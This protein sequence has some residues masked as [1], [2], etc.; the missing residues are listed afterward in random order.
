MAVE[1]KKKAPAKRR[2]AKKKVADKRPVGRPRVDPED[3][4]PEWKEEL[5]E[6]YSEGKSDLA[7]K[8]KC[9]KKHRVSSELWYRWMEE[10]EEFSTTVKFG[11][12]LSRLWWEELSAEHAS[13]V[14]SDANATSIIFNMTN[15]FRNGDDAWKQRQS[16]ETATKV[17]LDI[18]ELDKLQ[19]YLSDNGV[20]VTKL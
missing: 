19:E 11:R 4:N 16:V 9:F 14:N 18:D 6:H 12:E 15:R 7:A 1:P 17:S 20:D 8:T 13:G 10:H 5:I 3:Y 2:P